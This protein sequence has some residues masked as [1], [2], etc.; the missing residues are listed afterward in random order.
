MPLG[1]MLYKECILLNL[2][3][4]MQEILRIKW[5]YVLNWEWERGSCQVH[6]SDILIIV[7]SFSVYVERCACL[8]W[9]PLSYDDTSW[10]YIY[11]RYVFPYQ[12]VLHFWYHEF[13]LITLILAYEYK[14]K[15]L[16]FLNISNF[17]IFFIL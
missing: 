1:Y 9:L 15:Y 6:D 4:G 10:R 2:R 8:L 5:L 16:P 13:K 14:G 3:K 7:L 11:I 12:T 17:D